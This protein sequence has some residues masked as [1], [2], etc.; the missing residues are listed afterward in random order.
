MAT[1]EIKVKIGADTAGFDKG[2]DGVSGK[3]S[4]F[5]KVAGAAAAT[6]VVAL[7]TGMIALTKA[8]LAQIDVLTK[9]ARTLGLTT[10]AFQ[11]MTLVA[12]EAGIESGKLSS[13]LGLMQRNIAGLIDGT[14]AQTDAFG[15]LGL[16]ISDLQGLA[17]DE[18]FARIAASLDAITD[19]TTKTA[20]AMDVFGRSGRDAINMLTDY[21]AKAENAAEFQNRFGIAVSQ[22]TAEGVE[23]ANDAVGRLGMVMTGFGNTMAGAVAPAIEATA[24]ALIAFAGSAFGAKVSFEEFFGSIEMAKALLGENIVNEM[25]GKPESFI[26]H[27]DALAIVADEL[28]TLRTIASTAVPQIRI[29]ADE[30]DDLG[31]D[32]A[33]EAMRKIADD[34]K[35]AGEMFEAKAISAEEFNAKIREGV[36]SAQAIT[37]AFADIN[38]SDFSAAYSNIEGLAARLYN[39]AKAAAEVVRSLPGGSIE[40]A[41]TFGPGPTTATDLK[42]PTPGMTTG[43]NDFTRG[44][45][46]FRRPGEE[47]IPG[48]PPSLPGGGGGG[49]GAI[50]DLFAERLAALEEGLATEAEVISAW[51]EDGLTTLADARARG[52]VTEQEYMDLRERLE[53]EHQG[54]LAGIREIGNESAISMALGAGEEILSAIGQTNAKALKVAKVFGAAQALISAYQGAAEALKL[55]FPKN[56][57]AAAGV[58]AK[59]IGFVNAIRSVNSSGGGGGGGGGAASGGGGSATST[60]SSPMQVSLNTLGGGDFTSMLDLRALLTGLN[61]AA[62]DRGYTILVPQ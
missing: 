40:Q 6:A 35:L 15:A 5:S 59:G 30:L 41:T 34:V 8:S 28:D 57:A 38:G 4:T 11:K 61:T 21:S 22:S 10:E 47:L 37:A 39:A 31:E 3:L 36:A 29:F 17:P 33:A 44:S 54:R 45:L 46:G 1:P 23:R 19:P 51:Y 2:L 20:L 43:N 50:T 25:L 53:E 27:A 62:G 32:D 55:P 58:L 60:Q 18:Q 42:A 56:I 13:M 9:Q 7:A 16:S 14:Q 24:N 49:G 48:A 26:E 52:L 12:A